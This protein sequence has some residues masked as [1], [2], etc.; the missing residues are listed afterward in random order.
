MNSVTPR[1]PLSAGSAEFNPLRDRL[2]VMR[3]WL[4]I[5]LL[6]LLPGQF[7][8]AAAAS[9]CQHATDAQPEHFGHH[10]HPAHFAPA[11]EVEAAGGNDLP[12]SGA[13]IDCGHCH[14][15]LGGLLSNV[16]RLAAS[17]RGSDAAP[18]REC[19]PRTVA[20]APP[21]RPQWARLA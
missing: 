3:R 19:K 9:Y 7:V 10:E 5:L 11:G 2:Q 14:G 18:L 20:L 15:C 6:A 21:E 16:Q 12:G 17:S 4:V 1:S 13:G 8:W